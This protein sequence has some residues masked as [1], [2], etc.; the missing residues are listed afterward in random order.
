MSCDLLLLL[1]S[2]TL[3]LDN[4]DQQ[5]LTAGLGFSHHH[6][7]VLT[8]NLHVSNLLPGL[9]QLLQASLELSSFVSHLPPLL[10][11]HTPASK[12]SLAASVVKLLQQFTAVIMPMHRLTWL[13][14]CNAV[15][16]RQTVQQHI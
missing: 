9:L 1:I 10:L 15:I 2:H 12:Q 13:Y 11:Q 4:S 6:L 3:V 16:V 8:H 14:F 5:L 7:L